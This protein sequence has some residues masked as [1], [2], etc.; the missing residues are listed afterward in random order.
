MSRII[1]VPTVE[2]G[3]ALA[4]LHKVGILR[5]RHINQLEGQCFEKLPRYG[6]QPIGITTYDHVVDLSEIHF[7]VR[8]GHNIR[9]L[10]KGKL[11]LFISLFG[12]AA[13]YNTEAFNLH[14]FGLKDLTADLDV[15]YSADIWYPF[16]YQAVKTGIPTIAMEWENIPFNYE[17]RPYSKYK[18]Y[19]RQHAAHFIAITQKAKDAL[20]VEGVNP[21]KVSVVPAGIDCGT[22]KP[23][24]KNEQLAKQLGLSQSSVRI[25]FVGRLVSEKGIFD[26]LNAFSTLAQNND[27]ELLIR[28]SGLPEMV[29]EVN[30]L[31]KKLQIADKIKFIDRI[32]HY[33]DLPDI[34]N[35]ADIFC[36]PSIEI[37]GWAEQF[38]YV[39]A[40]AM[41]C[42]KPVVSTF[43]GSIPEVVKDRKTGLLVKQNDPAGLASALEQLVGD[44]TQRET[45]GLNA[46]QWALQRFEANKVAA[47]LAEVFSKFV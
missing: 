19:N 21:Q 31:I 44:K 45:F 39:L 46:R 1:L 9:T 34:Y 8:E 24:P 40:E 13:G 14:I 26:L 4:S 29:C 7:P 6:F 17:T 37:K 15:I 3:G 28:G 47:Q 20:V 12:K 33:T 18:K 16:T 27:V 36:L 43:S 38:G 42:G 23:A 11:K 32:Q 5:G 10:T 30:R 2:L 22:F 41:A 25:L 35:L